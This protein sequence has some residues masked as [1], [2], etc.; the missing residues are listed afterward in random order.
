MFRETFREIEQ[1]EPKI[2]KQ[3]QKSTLNLVYGTRRLEG[4]FREFL[5]MVGEKT[6]SGEGVVVEFLKK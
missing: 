6:T 3:Q 4:R 1:I 5:G 2:I